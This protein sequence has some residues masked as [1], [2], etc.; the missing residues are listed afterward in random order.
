MSTF[1]LVIE[2]DADE[3][4]NL[5]NEEVPDEVKTGSPETP[6][7]IKDYAEQYDGEI[8]EAITDLLL[9]KLIQYHKN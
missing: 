5:L 3:L 6:E 1:K 8:K 9:E 4:I 7:S 2:I